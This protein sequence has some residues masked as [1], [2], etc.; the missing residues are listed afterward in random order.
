MNGKNLQLFQFDYDLTWMAF[1]MDD[2]DHFYT[3]Y[4]DRDDCSA[5]SFLTKAS[6]LRV[7]RAVQARHA[8]GQ[9]QTSR[10]EPGALPVRTPEEIAPLQKRLLRRKPDQR[11]IHCH[12]VKMG[13]LQVLQQAG[14]F[15]KDMIFGYPPP[16]VV[17]IG[18]N[19]DEQDVIRSV[20]LGSPA[21]KAGLRS[22]DRLRNLDGQH[23]LTV[24]DF[25]RVLEL[26]PP[27]A[28]LPLE[29]QREGLAL[30]VT[31]RL[32]GAWRKTTDPSW[33]SSTYLAGPNAGFWGIA[34]SDAEKRKEGIPPDSQALL[35]N[36]FF[37]A[38]PTP[39]RSSLQ[40][41]DILVEFDG[42]RQPMTPRQIHTHCQMN[43]SYG[44]RLPIVVRRGGKEAK[45]T[46]WLPDKPAQLE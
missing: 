24:A 9:V 2:Q 26:T 42:Q 31:L 43:H 16:S 14:T 36:F 10:Y 15:R 29:V 33:R 40:L 25:A 27:E 11:C 22:G 39:A 18:V 7:M 23:L 1:F 12:D 21:A 19:P 20:A 44:D 3:R 45:L 30:Q 28:A 13:E 41:N 4:G 8:I 34:L 46:L 32:R 37:R 38:H 17:G 35:I 5:E 6:L